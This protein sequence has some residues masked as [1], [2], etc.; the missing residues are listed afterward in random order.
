MCGCC[1]RIARQSWDGYLSIPLSGISAPS[2]KDSCLR[3]SSFASGGLSRLRR[4][5]SRFTLVCGSMIQFSDSR[6]KVSPRT[7]WFWDLGI[8]ESI[9]ESSLWQRLGWHRKCFHDEALTGN[10]IIIASSK[11]ILKKSRVK[12]LALYYN[13]ALI[14]TTHEIIQTMAPFILVKWRDW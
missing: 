14:I 4:S 11:N 9:A 1:K 3:R 6:A 5:H 13:K 12:D 7:S 10:V 8:V 2:A